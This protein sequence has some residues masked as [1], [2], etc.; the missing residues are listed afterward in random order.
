MKNLIL[1]VMLFLITDKGFSATNQALQGQLSGLSVDVK[2]V[3]ENDRVLKGQKLRLD[4]VSS[5]GIPDGN[6][7]QFIETELRARLK[8]VL[9]DDSKLIL[10]VEYSYLESDTKTNLGK[11]VL[12]LS[13]KILD[14]GRPVKLRT[15]E[16]EAPSESLM[17]EVN[18]S[19]DISR[20]LGITIA[21]PDTEDHTKR[22][23][24]AEAGFEKP[25]FEVLA[26]TQVTTRDLKTYSVELRKSVGGKGAPTPVQPTNIN[27]LAFAP[28]DLS[29]T[30]SLALYNYDENAD[31]IACVDI[32][33]LDVANA[34]CVD[35]DSNGA[36]VLHRGYFVPRARAGKPGVHLIR[37][38]LHT[39]KPGNNNVFQFVVNELGKGAASA[40]NVKG[41]TGVVTVRFFDAYDEEEKPRSRS[42]GETG[43]G[44][45]QKEDYSLRSA[46]IGSEPVSI[47]SIRYSRIPN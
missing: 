17:R 40:L 46:Q 12:Q 26:E 10:K 28:V 33:G 5:T 32:D 37:G 30:Y 16:G 20:V 19:A 35:T 47:I 18:N 39:V 24:A 38:W 45:A 29:D 25:A 41:K 34:F 36:R 15:R 22:L 42:F 43:I 21:V 27:G 11:R 3:L 31:A 44:K 2:A 9:V 6:Y 23:A 4:R 1:L 7:D 8:D 14:R 13:A